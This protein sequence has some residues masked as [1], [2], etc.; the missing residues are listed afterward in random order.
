MQYDM[1]HYITWTI[2]KPFSL[3]FSI[4]YHSEAFSASKKNKIK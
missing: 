2:L 1:K 4:Y 3:D